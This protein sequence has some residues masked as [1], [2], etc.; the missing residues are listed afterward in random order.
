MGIMAM[1]AG[2]VQQVTTDTGGF[3]TP[4]IF[5]VT[6]GMTTTVKTCNAVVI[7]HGL[8]IDERGIS[9][10]APTSRIM[11]SELA[12]KALSFPTRD[13]NYKL[14]LK[15]AAVTF[16]DSTTGQQV[17]FTIKMAVGNDFTAMVSC[18]LE[19]SGIMTPAGRLIIGWMPGSIIAN[20]TATPGSGTQTLANGDIIPTDY[21]MNSDRTLTI[22]YMVGYSALSSFFL[23][24]REIQ[25]VAYTKATGTFSNAGHGGFN[26]TNTIKFD[27]SI[28]IWQS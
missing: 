21:S 14:A 7:L 5:S 18:T 10:V 8:Y 22:P 24:G 16:T 20:I 1:A 23:N 15:G 27:G 25:D 3:A 11:V 28:P 2:L 12:L 26:N 6:N 17:I 4:V 19:Q 9:M 13:T